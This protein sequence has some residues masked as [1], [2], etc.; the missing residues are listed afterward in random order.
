MSRIKQVMMSLLL[1]SPMLHAQAAQSA[2]EQPDALPLEMQRALYQ[3]TAQLLPLAAQKQDFQ[4]IDVML[5]KLDGYILT[6]YL[7]YQRLLLDPVALSEQRIDEFA[8]AH[9]EIADRD[10][11]N[12]TLLNNDFKQQRWQAINEFLSHHTLD[13]QASQC[14]ALSAQHHLASDSAPVWQAVTALWQTGQ[15]LPNQCDDIL[16][17]WQQARQMTPELLRKR[18]YLAFLAGSDGLLRHLRNLATGDDM[19][20]QTYL[21]SLVQLREHPEQLPVFVQTAAITPENSAIVERTFSRFLKTLDIALLNVDDPFSEFAPWA[22]RFHLNADQIAAW[23]AALVSK[24]FDES[25]PPLQQWRDAQ[26]QAL[27]NDTLTERRIRTALLQQEALAP[28]LAL[29]SQEA[30][31]KQEWRYWQAMSD[32]KQGKDVREQL[33]AL[34]QERGFYSMLAATKLGVTYQPHFA[35]LSDPQREQ[36]L[37][38]LK[39]R[40]AQLQEL[41][42]LSQQSTANAVWQ[43]LLAKAEQAQKIALAEYANGQGWYDL[44][45]QATIAAKAWDYISARL[46]QAFDT[47]FEINL[48]GKQVPLSFAQAIARQESAWNPS[49][50]SSADARGLMQLLPSTAKQTAQALK[51]PYN[52]AQALFSPFDNIMLGT[53]HLQQLSD[54]FDGNR[55]LM[56]SAYNAGSRR[57]EQWLGRAGGKL[58]MAEFIATIPYYETRGYVQNVLTYDYYYQL[59]RH[60]QGIS[61]AKSEYDRIY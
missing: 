12:R 23:K 40:L 2:V 60:G 5:S 47:W 28:W 17:Q 1:V 3:K 13:D 54:R 6:P 45:V 59:L 61:F 49:V 43:Q 7:Q 37:T 31:A 44:G 36:L 42:T 29:L 56:A 27:R 24:I 15:S 35:Q 32:E 25:A 38:P 53:A 14:I 10:E 20:S 34:S 9:P 46:P 8:Q 58:S 50:T 11:L 30:A 16:T 22:T 51:L 33:N 52:N 39:V 26:V 4:L 18:G 48:A 41:R 55:I 21:E 19:V 57:V